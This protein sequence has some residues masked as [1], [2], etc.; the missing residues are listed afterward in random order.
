MLTDTGPLLALINRNDPHHERCKA[1]VRQ[2]PAAPLLTTWPCWTEAMYLL[3]RAGGY[4]A[5]ATWW[6]WRAGGQV[7]LLDLA[8]LEIDRVA[9]LMAKYRDRPMDLADA[10]L[11]VI[12]ERLGLRQVFTVDGDFHIYRLADGAALESV[13]YRA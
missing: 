8:E 3:Y 1:A 10:S 9:V 5:Q 4:P 6:R 13:P 7:R 2:W 12:A 11:V